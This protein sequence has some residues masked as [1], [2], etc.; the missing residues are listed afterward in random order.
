MFWAPH[1]SGVLS[2]DRSP[3]RM[4]I[5]IEDELSMWP[6]W[7]PLDLTNDPLKI[8]CYLERADRFTKAIS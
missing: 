5:S 6:S 2:P 4:I 7:W 3:D 8:T 1:S